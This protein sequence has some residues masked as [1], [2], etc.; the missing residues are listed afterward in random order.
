M[1][2]IVLII[3]S[4]ESIVLL[5][6]SLCTLIGP[7]DVCD[8]KP[9]QIVQALFTYIFVPFYCVKLA[10]YFRCK[11]PYSIVMTQIPIFIVYQLACSAWVII[12]LISWVDYIACRPSIYTFNLGFFFVQNLQS[13][14]MIVMLPYLGF[15]L[16]VKVTRDV[17]EINFKIKRLSKIRTGKAT[18]LSQQCAIC[19]EDYDE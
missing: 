6:I 18:D 9:S 13:L 14:L 4:F 7:I 19:I 16:W 8:A 2:L 3:L 11:T 5:Y 17:D 15:R 12:C 10:A 1:R